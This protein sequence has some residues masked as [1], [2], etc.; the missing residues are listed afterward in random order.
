MA[1]S[2]IGRLASETAIYGISSVVGR[3]INFLLFPLY[4]QVFDPDVYQPV[5][6][7]YAAFIFLNI[8]YQHGMESSYLK[9]AT[10]RKEGSGRSR[11]FGTAVLS[12]S[13]VGLA[14][15]AL[16]WLLPDPV[17]RV[18]QLDA[19]YGELLML[20]GWILLLDAL[21][22]VPFADL[23]LRNQPWRFAGIRLANIAVNVGLNLWFIFGLDWGVRGVLMAN[24]VASGVS[25]FL[26][27]PTTLSRFGAPD[28]SLWIQL[29][30]FG[31]PFIPGGIGYAITERINLFFLEQM[32]PLQAMAKYRLTSET[33]PDLHAR[34]LEFG[35]EVFTDHVVGVYGGIIKLAVLMA[36][37]VQMFRYAWQP[38]FLQHQDDEDAPALYGRVFRLL[39]LVLLTAFLG[40]SFF[41]QELVALPLPGGRTLIAES[42]WLGL[43]I[44]PLALI[45]YVFQGWYYHFSAGAYIRGLS[46]YFL[47]ATLAGS[48]VAL[49]LNATLVP[50]Q[51]MMAA[52]LATSAA[53]AVMAMTLLMFIR[54]HYPVPYA[55][56]R[57][58]AAA[59][60]A[61]VCFMAW[62]FLPV[63]QVWYLEL[64]LVGAFALMTARMLDIS[65]GTLRETT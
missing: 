22:I 7:L 1:A 40:I 6:I 59:L 33:H 8:L 21:A 50:T 9:F 16:I 58:G 56:G 32:E 14:L 49:T 61:M 57:V 41:A 20:G 34:A 11:T 31:L 55:W 35:N 24:V 48:A 46:K 25:L 39:T 23:R 19:R 47:H 4:S 13:L 29:L 18:I 52:A 37:F 10:D 5:A 38:F 36:L 26:L 28:G 12:V 17:S 44:I 54:G 65:V 15:S 42:Y 43:S 27:L 64:V 63:L 30:R 60:L 45:G 62:Y 3:L 53:Y 51:G 2:R